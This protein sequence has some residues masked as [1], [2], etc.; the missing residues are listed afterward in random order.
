MFNITKTKII[1]L[2]NEKFV[3]SIVL[4]SFFFDIQSSTDHDVLDCL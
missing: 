4:Q 3:S 2:I 1:I